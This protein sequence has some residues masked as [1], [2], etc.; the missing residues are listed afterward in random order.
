MVRIINVIKKNLHSTA[1]D[2]NEYK[3]ENKGRN[4]T[5]N[6]QDNQYYGVILLKK[7]SLLRHIMYKYKLCD[8]IIQNTNKSLTA[9]KTYLYV[10]INAN[11][12]SKSNSQILNNVNQKYIKYI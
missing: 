11:F 2:L 8:N 12:S 9:F 3:E 4:R 6:H 5:K 10:I 7:N 1:E